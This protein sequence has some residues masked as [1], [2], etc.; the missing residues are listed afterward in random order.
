MAKQTK[1]QTESGELD[2]ILF[3]S[4]GEYVPAGSWEIRPREGKTTLVWCRVRPAGGE[5]VVQQ[6]FDDF[7]K[8]V[9]GTKFEGKVTVLFPA[10]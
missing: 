9:K 5:A 3:D 7:R 8:A 2:Q 4:I 1:K 6:A 10:E